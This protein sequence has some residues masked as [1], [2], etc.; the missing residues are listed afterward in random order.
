MLCALQLVTIL[1]NSVEMMRAQSKLLRICIAI[2]AVMWVCDSVSAYQESMLSIDA[3]VVN[4]FREEENLWRNIS[5]PG[6]LRNETTNQIYARHE[7]NLGQDF[8][9]LGVNESFNWHIDGSI[10]ELNRISE[11]VYQLLAFR[12]YDELRGYADSVVRGV[13][14]QLRGVFEET[15][16]KTFLDR[17]RDVCKL[18]IS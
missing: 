2:G 12:K 8:G 11:K 3:I 14:N 4:Y 13:P 6:S 7:V 16:K 5:A 10:R 15:N 9:Q 17:I 18:R 1:T